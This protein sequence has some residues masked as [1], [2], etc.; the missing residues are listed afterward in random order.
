MAC[1]RISVY[2]L[3][4]KKCTLTRAFTWYINTMYVYDST[5]IY[6]YQIHDVF[7]FSRKNKKFKKNK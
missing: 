4:F 1:A 2:A 7:E 5:Y 3:Q 6:A